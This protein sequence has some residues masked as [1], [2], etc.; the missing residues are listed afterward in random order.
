M[1]IPIK[2]I[3]ASTGAILARG[4]VAGE[5]SGVSTD[6]RTIRPGDD[7]F[8]SQDVS[9]VIEDDPGT[10]ALKRPRSG[11]EEVREELLENGISA[12]APAKR[13]RR[14]GDP[15]G[16]DVDDARPDPRDDI[17][18]RGMSQ[19]RV[20]GKRGRDEE[21]RS[22]GQDEERPDGPRRAPRAA[23]DRSGERPWLACLNHAHTVLA[24]AMGASAR[25]PQ[26]PDFR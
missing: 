10:E 17:D 3:L 24:P 18:G 7:V 12:R 13:T 25:R 9:Q 5:A 20:G 14:L 26:H 22:Q 11:L 19:E 4:T 2:D 21:D 23:L 15:F 1:R 6:T 16:R 8:V